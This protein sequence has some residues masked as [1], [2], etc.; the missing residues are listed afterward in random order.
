MSATLAGLGVCAS[1][2]PPPG[3]TDIQEMA[4]SR[5][6]GVGMGGSLHSVTP[7]PPYPLNLCFHVP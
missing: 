4:S 7:P 5:D 2:S 1:T 6:A 3:P